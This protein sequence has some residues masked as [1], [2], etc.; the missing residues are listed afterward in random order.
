MLVLSRRLQEKILIPEFN[1]SITILRVG[2]NRVQL[3]I[4]A[5]REIEINRPDTG[6]RANAELNCDEVP[7]HA[8]FTSPLQLV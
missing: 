4:E 1:I 6:R 8:T 3:G 7:K 5:P 2:G